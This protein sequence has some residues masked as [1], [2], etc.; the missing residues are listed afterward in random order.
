MLRLLLELVPTLLIGLAL[1]WR[2]PA[3]A[4]RCAPWLLRWGMPISLAGMVLRAGLQPR[5]A[6][7]ALVTALV[8]GGAVLALNRWRHLDHCLP[9]GALRLGAVVGNT[10]YL[11]LPV[12]L[13]LLPSKALPVSITIDLIGTLITWGLGPLLLQGRARGGLRSLVPLLWRS[14][15]LRAVVLALPMAISPWAAWFGSWLWWPSRCLL[16]LLLV[17]IGTRLAELLRQ[18]SNEQAAGSWG[19]VVPA[20]LSKLVIWPLLMG[21]MACL[22]GASAP[23]LAAVVLQAAQPSAMS[24]VL[25]AEG[26]AGPRRLVEVQSA[27]RVVLISTVL[28]AL[29]LPLW[30]QALRWFVPDL[31]P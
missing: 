26:V 27:T 4:E 2:W 22:A 29:T 14:P 9:T 6:W 12:A 20:L 31:A 25:L 30:W 3:L 7:I 1:G 18:L 13:A 28:S 10:G 15:V 24:V 19:Q 11:G 8:C 5:L 16:W 21:A 23:V 17:L